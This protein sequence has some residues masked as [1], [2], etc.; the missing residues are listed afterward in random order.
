MIRDH[1][2]PF[3]P[4]EIT[5]GGAK[6]DIKCYYSV[7][8]ML[9][10][11]CTNICILPNISSW[12][13]R[14]SVFDPGRRTWEEDSFEG[15]SG[16]SLWVLPARHNVELPASVDKLPVP[17]GSS[18]VFCQKVDAI[19]SCEDLSLTYKE[20]LLWNSANTFVTLKTKPFVNFFLFWFVIFHEEIKLHFFFII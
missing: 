7:T 8:L 2:F 9:K 10:T 20:Q 17:H 12:R 1:S 6:I 16:E 11:K 14:F 18:T 13:S 19:L 15:D 4:K 3:H 5:L